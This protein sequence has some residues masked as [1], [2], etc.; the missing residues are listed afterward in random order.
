MHFREMSVVIEP[1]RRKEQEKETAPILADF[2]ESDEKE[3]TSV[4]HRTKWSAANDL[5]S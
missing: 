3:A 1:V 2:L 5:F 4:A